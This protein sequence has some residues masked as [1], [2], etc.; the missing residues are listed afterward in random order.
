MKK[1]LV[2]EKGKVTSPYVSKLTKEEL[3]EKINKTLR[4]LRD[5]KRI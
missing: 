5:K 3:T 4:R 2:I 1:Y